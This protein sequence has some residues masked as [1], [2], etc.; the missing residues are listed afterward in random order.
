[1]VGD[2]IDMNI[3]DLLCQNL[4]DESIEKIDFDELINILGA[5][6]ENID[7]EQ[8]TVRE[9]EYLKEEYRNRIIGMVKANL[10]CRENERDT[11][12][13][14]RLSDDISGIS[15]EELVGIYG[16]AAARFR[17]NFPASFRYL[18]IPSPHT[19]NQKNWNEHKI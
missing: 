18:A 12:L 4:A 7:Q 3:I 5:V 1:M 17:A 6:R 9:L 19:A 15:A 10:A 16:R 8:K 11:E 13:A 2:K 14:V